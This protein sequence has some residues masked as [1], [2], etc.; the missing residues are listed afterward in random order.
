MLKSLYIS[1]FIIIDE[2]RVNFDEGMSVLTGETGAGK[3]IIID[4]L[5]QLCGNRTSTSLIKKKASKAIIEGIF[6]VIESEELKKICEK[7]HIELEEEFVITKEILS[8]GKSN[9]KI[10]YQNASI[11]ALKLLMPYL[12]DIHSQFETQ[13]LFEEKNHIILLDQY[14]ND[15]LKLYIHQ[16]KDIYQK[17][18]EISSHLNHVIEEDMSDEQLD[19]LQSQLNEI[20]ESMYTDEEI[21]EFESEL[22]LLQNY[23]KINENIQQFDFIM[24]SSNG[25]LTQMKEALHTLQILQDYEE[26]NES[27]DKMYDYY[28]NI[29]DEH[30]NIMS[31][32]N[33]FH[34]DEYRFNELQD[35]LFKVN[36]LKRKYGYTMERINEYRIELI[37][38]IDN[39]KHRDEYIHSLQKEQ[40][41]IKNECIKLAENIHTIR[42]K[43]A[44][45]FEK[46]IIH[47]LKDLYLEKANF[48]VDFEKTHLNNQGI[49]KISFK[50]AINKGQDYSLLNESAS[51]GEIS[52]IMLAI[53]TV[54]LSYGTI[55]TIV[56]DEVDT[57]VSGKVARSI[58]NKMLNLSK[59]KQVICITHL[60]QVASL[61]HHHYS[62]EKEMNNEETVTSMKRLHSKERI[63]EIAKML[64]SE[65]IT[66]EA[67]ENAKQLLNV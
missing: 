8:S 19:F 57:G 54:I 56:F 27:Y 67:I 13:K 2:L 34:F 49:D 35:I 37:E 10:N 20:E 40:K 31:I 28:Y 50:V 38:K 4:A 45:K 48:K 15:E 26:F 63:I 41:E 6:D 43:Y 11:N 23:E 39:I 61:A 32:Y 46:A 14:A 53:K 66:D 24:N 62:I 16:Y 51:G 55:D 36:R 18:K 17:Y 3:S 30:E 44:V 7:L 29:Q 22:K 65:K 47:E 5:G 9:V 52:R 12:I 25:I 64:S 21:E 42:K 60:P 1:S 58:G 59:S 33:Q